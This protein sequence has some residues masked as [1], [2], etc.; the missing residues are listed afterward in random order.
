MRSRLDAL[1]ELARY[2]VGWLVLAA[3]VVVLALAFANGPAPVSTEDA[4]QSSGLCEHANY[5][6]CE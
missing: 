6:E 4:V 2:L 1:G 5:D 3:V